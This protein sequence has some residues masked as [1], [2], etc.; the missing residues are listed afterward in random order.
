MDHA[1]V[2]SLNALEKR[3]IRNHSGNRSMRIMIRQFF[4]LRARESKQ[5]RLVRQCV[6]GWSPA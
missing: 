1:K 3:G 4:W 6:A 2:G 5:E